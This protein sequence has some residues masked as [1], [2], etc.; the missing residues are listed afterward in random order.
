MSTVTAYCKGWDFKHYQRI[1][2]GHS[3]SLQPFPSGVVGHLVLSIPPS[4]QPRGESPQV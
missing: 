1:L 3:W 4:V 2:F